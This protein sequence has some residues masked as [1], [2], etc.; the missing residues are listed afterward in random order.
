MKKI[1]HVLDLIEKFTE[2]FGAISIGIMLVIS[3]LEVFF[4]DALNAPL[5]WSLSLTILIM[6]WMAMLISGTGVRTNLHI[7]VA[8]FADTLPKKIKKV[9]DVVVFSLLL[10]FGY[11][12]VVGAYSMAL[13]PGIMPELGISNSWLYIPVMVGGVLTIVFSGERIVRIMITGK[14]EKA[15]ETK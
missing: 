10:Y 15:G 11:Y 8:A 13:L 4:R 2:W 14:D 1:E 5:T 6:I 12:M 7:R 9:V 3:L